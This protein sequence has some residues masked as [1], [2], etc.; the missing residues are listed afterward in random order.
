MPDGE[1]AVRAADLTFLPCGI[2]EFPA[3][4]L[5]ERLR[6]LSKLQ[7]EEALALG[8]LRYLGVSSGSFS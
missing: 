5:N 3:G 8:K 7:G 1:P 2:K 6:R 4:S